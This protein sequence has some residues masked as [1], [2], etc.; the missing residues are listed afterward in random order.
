MDNDI[1]NNIG[2]EYS[3][4]IE[5]ETNLVEYNPYFTEK[6]SSV[7]EIELNLLLY[8]PYTFETLSID[9]YNI[10]EI[11]EW[12]VTDDFAPFISDDDNEITYYFKVTKLSMLP[13]VFS[14]EYQ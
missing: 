4:E 11:Y 2:I 10:N 8:N 1:L 12:L 9:N 7:E 5:V 13:D 3:S 6:P 14:A